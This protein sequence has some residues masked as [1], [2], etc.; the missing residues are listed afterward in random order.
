MLIAEELGDPEGGLLD[1][2][3][4]VME[5]VEDGPSGDLEK[6]EAR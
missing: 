5:D 3:Q 1:E 4:V 6:T 2:A